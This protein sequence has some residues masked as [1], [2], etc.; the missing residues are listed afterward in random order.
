[1]GLSIALGLHVL[2]AMALTQKEIL[3]YHRLEQE[4]ITE[5]FFS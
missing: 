1:M 5:Q 2:I 3:D 4:T